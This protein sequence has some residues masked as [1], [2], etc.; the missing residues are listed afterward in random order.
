MGGNTGEISDEIYFEKLN[1]KYY[2]Y[3]SDTNTVVGFG[4]N[5]NYSIW[6]DN[7][8]VEDN[9][10]YGSKILA[11]SHESQAIKIIDLKSGVSSESIYARI[12][13]NSNDSSKMLLFDGKDVLLS[14]DG[15]KTSSKINVDESTIDG[16]AP[17]RVKTKF[18][19]K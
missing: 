7:A 1:L 16:V 2:V 5:G 17:D 13:A 4:E 15:K 12:M 9:L 6:K 11:N 19:R 18:Q 14:S 8:V 3:N 10:K